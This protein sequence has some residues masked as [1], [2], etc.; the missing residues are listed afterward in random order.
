MSLRRAALW[1]GTDMAGPSWLAGI[2]AAVMILTAAY[3]A[4]RLAI[5]RLRRRAIEFDTDALHA[6]MGAAMAGML[7]PRLNVLP[8]GVWAA[9]FGIA[10]AWFGWHAMRQRGPVTAGLLSRFGVPHLIE[11]VTM[12]YML[13]SVHGS[14]PMHGGKAM[15]GMGPSAGP[16]GSFP[17]LAVVLA[18]FML[19]YI[20]WT[21]DGLTSLARAKT[22]RAGP[23]RNLDRPSPAAV[24]AIPSHAVGEAPGTPA[25]TGTRRGDRA[26]RLVLAPGFAACGKLVMSITMGYMLILMF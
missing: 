13:L 18:L 21:T 17:V 16:A 9:V 7:V 20:V 19:G 15:A 8:N 25:A 12:L 24:L 22:M 23:G 3:S 6:A 11:C 2:L 5:S 10:A 4:S 26:D 14:R 1:D